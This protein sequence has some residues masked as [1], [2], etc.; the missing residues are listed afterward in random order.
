MEIYLKKSGMFL[1]AESISSDE[2]AELKDG[3]VYKVT[4]TK[5]RNYK[6]HKKFF[7]LIKAAYELWQPIE[8]DNVQKSFDVFRSEITVLCGYYDQVFTI[9]GGFKLV[10]KSISFAKMDEETFGKLFNTAIQVILDNVLTKY[11]RNDLDRAVNII[12]RYD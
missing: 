3:E 5:P 4:L 10:A 9:G 1:I 7:S 12:L 2:Y 6:F 11:T 8:T